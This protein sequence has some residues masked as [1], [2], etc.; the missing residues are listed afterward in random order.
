MSW[1]IFIREWELLECNKMVKWVDLFIGMFY[2][3]DRDFEFSI[4]ISGMKN[5]FWIG[6]IMKCDLKLKRCI[7]IFNLF[8]N[9]MFGILLF[10]GEFLVI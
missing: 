7:W 4:F 2:F 6:Y 1:L 3:M 8:F 5:V 9:N 10:L